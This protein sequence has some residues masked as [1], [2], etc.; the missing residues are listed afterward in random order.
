MLFKTHYTNMIALIISCLLLSV[1]PVCAADNKSNI[2]NIIVGTYSNTSLAKEEQG[3]FL[4][5]YDTDKHTFKEPM[6]VSNAQ[7]TSYT[8]YDKTTKILYSVIEEDA[9]RIVSHQWSKNTLSLEPID[10]ISSFGAYPCFININPSFNQLAVANYNSGNIAIVDYDAQTGKFKRNT[11]NYT[12]FG[13]SVDLKRQ[14]RSHAHWVKWSKDNK[15]LYTV[16]L[17]IDKIFIKSVDD[18]K[19]TLSDSKVA[20]SLPPGSGPRHMA[21]HPNMKVA[22][23]INE[24]NNTLTVTKVEK[25]GK[26]N[27]TQT[28]ST[29]PK[30]SQSISQAGHMQI[31]EDGKFLY[32]TNRGD[33]SIGVYAI[34]SQGNVELIQHIDT[35]GEWPRFFLITPDGKS[36]LVANQHTNNISAFSIN[37]DGLLSFT[38]N[39]VLISH[40]V[41]LIP[42]N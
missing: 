13:N 36:L 8:N 40:P 10:S 24:L 18:T 6:L 26:L 15:Y 33:N 38:G 12:F 34:K 22:Y 4:L 23:V 42:V 19:H 25:S 37:N 21:F 3:V 17:G 41:S 11:Q 1:A 16:N 39:D 14:R 31:S 30:G 5:Q 27:H 2:L 29:L 35:Q 28:V 20:L 32:V 9:G 7:N